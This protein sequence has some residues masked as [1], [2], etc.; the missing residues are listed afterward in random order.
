MSGLTDDVHER[1][2]ARFHVELG[3]AGGG[4][5]ERHEGW[6]AV[7]GGSPIAYDNAV[8]G[9]RLRDD[10][11]DDVMRTVA[12]RLDELHAPG[13]WHLDEASTPRDLADRL[14]AAGCTDG[15]TDI[16]MLFDLASLG[17]APLVP[18]DVT[19]HEVDTTRD[20]GPASASDWIEVLSE[21]FGEGPVEAEWAGSVYR[22]LGAG[23]DAAH[24]LYVALQGTVPV[25]AAASLIDGDAVGIF[26]VGTRP[27]ARCQGIGAA[28]T[29]R[30][31]SDGAAGG[32]GVAVLGASEMGRPVYARLGFEECGR[33]RI[34]ER[35]ATPPAA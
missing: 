4:V 29:H 26:F 34:L 21:G 10:E 28:V 18:A 7:L 12:E 35:T 27:R 30:A 14:L 24:H 1:V 19:I 23:P 25:G 3:V 11:A 31:A 20:D 6:T 16:G 17:P 5:V 32:C 33:T 9:V 2:T 13:S 15:G 22:R 8:F